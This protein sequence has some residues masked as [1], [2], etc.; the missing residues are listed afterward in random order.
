MRLKLPAAAA[1][2]LALPVAASG[3]AGV[4]GVRTGYATRVTQTTARLTGR[5]KPDGQTTRYFFQY[6]TS[7][8]YGRRTRVQSAGK[9]HRA[10]PV[11]A[12]L[13]GLRPSRRYH[14]RLVATCRGCRT[15]YGGDHAFRTPPPLPG[16]ATGAASAVTQSSARLGG[17]VNPYR[18]R[19]TYYF[20]YGPSSAYGAATAAGSTRSRVPVALAAG[21]L[22]SGTTY[23]Y[24]LVATHCG[25]CAV[26]TTAGA[27][28][29]FTTQQSPQQ[30]AAA[31]AVATYQ[32]MQKYFYA[33]NAYPGDTTSLYAETYPPSGNRYSYLWPFSRALVG[34]LTLSGVPQ[35]LLSG[36]GY[37]PDV[38]DRLAGLSHYWDAGAGAYD[39][40]VP[41][42]LGPGGDRYNDDQAW[43]GLALAKTYQ[44]NGD[45]AALG[46]A[47]AVFNYVYPSQFDT[48]SGDFDPGGIF[49]VAQ[50]TG[51]GATN[52][53]R[54]NTAN[55]PNAELASLLAQLDPVHSSSYEA[56]ATAMYGWA[57]HYLY[58]VPSNPNHDATRPALM[59][60]K[61]TNGK[62]DETLWTYNQGVM[63][64]ANVAAYRATGETA[65][66][67]EAETLAGAALSAFTE[68][69]YLASQPPAFNAIYFRGLLQLYAV[70]AD[71]SLRARILQA[72]QTYSDDV[73]SQ[74]RD[75]RGLFHFPISGPA[76]RLLDQGAMLQIYSA[77][78]WDPA[79]YS[80]LP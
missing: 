34:T 35:S 4:P 19:T 29:T 80:K 59:F 78:A 77:L 6:G 42:P 60:D 30:I 11:A 31:R 71:P 10:S 73:W 3:A 67:S 37:Q 38:A 9:R 27:D 24:R 58:D 61:V 26:G 65:Y 69:D 72:L 17:I 46:G 16:A 41:A 52:H 32:A 43:V 54:T 47:E 23:H 33:A 18:T 12:T 68:G 5:V 22:A 50:G 21:N 8:R 56:G 48:A 66:L 40:Y 74:Y 36:A 57:N 63:I 45:V 76:D 28:V 64:A 70:T 39:S 55:A 79:D 44:L 53:D 49:W 2:A 13:G 25:S 20:Q 62:I 1:L 15:R 51:K 75:S 7:R 14:Y